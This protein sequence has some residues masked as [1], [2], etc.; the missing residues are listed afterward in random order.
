VE[1][2]AHNQLYIVMII[3]IGIWLGLYAYLFNLDARLKKL[4][5]NAGNNG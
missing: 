3:V 5:R 1:F 2:L 4:E